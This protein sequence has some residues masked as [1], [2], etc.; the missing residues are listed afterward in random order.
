MWRFISIIAA[1]FALAACGPPEMPRPLAANGANEP[2]HSAASL[3]GEVL[4]VDH[5]APADSLASGTRVELRPSGN[6][7]V[8]VDLAPGWYLDEQGIRYSRTDRVQVEGMYI[9]G[10]G[11][12]VL[13][14]NRVTQGG[15]TVELRDIQGRPLWPAESK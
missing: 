6:H 7:S 8:V 2:A 15:R 10:R 5:T 11:R 13:Y 9:E 12:T 1:A 4:G 14:A 3:E